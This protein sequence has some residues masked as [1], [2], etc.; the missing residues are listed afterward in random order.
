MKN[1][2]FK[3]SYK[4]IIFAGIF[5][6]IILILS[7]S[8]IGWKPFEGLDNSINDAL[9]Q[10]KGSTDKR[11]TIVGIDE[12]TIEKYN[13]YNAIEYREH[14]ANILNAWADKDYKPSA[15][16]FDIIFNKQYG[17]DEVDIKLKDAMKKQNVILGVNG[18]S[19]TEAPYGLSE[20][21]YDG[22]KGIGYV[23]AIT[24]NDEAIRRTYL[25]S[26]N[27]DSLAYSLYST[28]CDK[29]NINKTDYQ[30]K[31]AYYFNY[32]ASPEIITIDGKTA[33]VKS[34]F[35]YISLKDLLDSYTD[36]DI[37]RPRGQIV[38]FGSYASAVDTGLSNDI[39]NSPI[40][41]MF[42]MEVQ[43]N[44]I[45]SLLNDKLYSPAPIYLSTI[46]N[47]ILIFGIVLLMTSVAF[48]LGIAVFI[49][50]IGLE[51]IISLIMHS[52]GSYY[53]MSTPLLVIVLAFVVMIILHYYNEYKHKREVIGTFK[54]YI[55]P[56]VAE[57]LVDKDKEAMSLGGR[58]RNVACLF[59]DIRGFTKMS[60]ELQ[61]EEVVDILN[62]YLEMATNQV[63]RFGGMVDKFIGDC[64]MA[65]FNA[66][67]DLD[68]YV[69]KAVC[70]A[71]GIVKEG[72]AICDQVLEKYN[73]KLEFGV[74]VHYGDAVIGNIG[75]KTR[76][77]FTA[78]GDTVNTASRIEASAGGSQVLISSFVYDVIKDRVKVVDAGDR[79]FKNKKEPIK[80]YE[81][82]EIEGYDSFSKE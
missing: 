47:T 49:L 33:D 55:S 50:G 46:I 48:Y 4:N 29:N 13:A 42:G 68:D 76:M 11:I 12:P 38:L 64:V 10:H 72:K 41:E 5:A 69:F 82:V 6:L 17:C 22:A 44:I 67:V 59:V 58:K 26:D 80:C 78:I 3:F 43:C 66:P 24:D 40:G 52:S 70:A 7:I 1:K 31:K 25:K 60:E 71:F 73:K 16:G 9:Y 23:D 77:D 75:S 39:Y 54:R 63:F 15:I 20:T 51:F 79:M 56:D 14:F 74:G 18:M 2:I 57:A 81:V 35:D 21:I 36:G 62:G 28:Y 53:F 45:Q 61:P 37:Y 30:K 19:R 34:G 27:Y 8:S 65:I 32:Y